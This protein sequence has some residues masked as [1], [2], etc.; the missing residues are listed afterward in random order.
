MST[1]FSV[2]VKLS[3]QIVCVRK[4]SLFMS[5]KTWR[6]KILLLAREVKFLRART[7][8]IL[9]HFFRKTRAVDVQELA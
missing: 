6:G 4:I 3:V 5:R 7:K 9:R 8:K 1:T 2:H